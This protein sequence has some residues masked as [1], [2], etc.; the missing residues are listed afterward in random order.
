MDIER[1]IESLSI[2]VTDLRLSDAKVRGVS[3]AGPQ[4]R[5][6]I[7]VHLSYP[8]NSYL[9]GRSKRISNSLMRPTVGSHFPVLNTPLKAMVAARYTLQNPL[10]C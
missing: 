10:V 4:H 8:A 7:V 5:P 2:Q 6:G 9:W 1:L 3:I